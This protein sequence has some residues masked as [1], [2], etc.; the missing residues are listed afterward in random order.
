M[1]KPRVT[2]SRE[3]AAHCL[4]WLTYDLPDQEAGIAAQI[5]TAFHTL[6]EGGQLPMALAPEIVYP[7]L[8]R[9]DGWKRNGAKRLPK[10]RECEV[11]FAINSAG[12]VRRI[13]QG[14][15]R[16][17][18]EVADDEITGTI[19]V[20]G[21]SRTIDF[22]TGRKYVSADESFQLD[23]ASAATNSTKKEFHYVNE[24]GRTTVDIAESDPQVALKVVAEVARRIRDGETAANPGEWCRNHYCPARAHCAAFCKV[25]NINIKPLQQQQAMTMAET[26]R[27]ALGAVT[28]GKIKRPIKAVIYGKEGV[29]K[30]T[31]ASQAPAPIFL[32]AEEGSSHLDVARFPEPRTWDDAKSA[33][34]ELKGEHQYKTLVVDSLDWL[35]PLISRFVMEKENMT[36]A[37]YQ[38]FGAGEKHALKQWKEFI[39]GLDELRDQRGM[40][41][42]LLAH[43]QLVEFRNPEGDDFQRYQLSL[44]PKAGE[45]FKQY[46]DYLLFL[47]WEIATKKGERSVKGIF[48]D[49]LIYTECT[50]AFDAKNRVG[51]A[52]AIP[53]TRDEAWKAFADAARE[54]ARA[55]QP[56]QPANTNKEEAAA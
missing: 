6:A 5:G 12:Q 26:N 30:S 21:E 34:A 55:N 35:H 29:G 47:G 50:A 27:M 23:F 22:K 37:Q 7:A 4:H 14:L 49:R 11:S 54:A 13:G 19:D 17:Y 32:C 31:F 18:G 40:H 56:Q 2:A 51:L 45:M 28:R 16:D 52:P 20:F 53:F 44:P 36:E 25:N 1:T 39:V 24:D 48:G 15:G 46:A 10:E 38:A 43:S 9:F 41:I 3:L 8:K 42:L 33:L